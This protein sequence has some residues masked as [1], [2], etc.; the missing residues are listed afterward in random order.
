[1]PLSSP[2]LLQAHDMVY[3]PDYTTMGVD[4]QQQ[5]YQYQ[6]VYDYG[7][8]PHGPEELEQHASG[9]F[10]EFNT[11]ESATS[12]N[13][14]CTTIDGY[15]IS[16]HYDSSSP[17]TP[18]SATQAM[19]VMYSSPMTELDL[20]SPCFSPVPAAHYA[21]YEEE[22]HASHA[23]PTLSRSQSTPQLH[24]TVPFPAETTGL[25][26]PGNQPAG[27]CM[28]LPGTAAAEHASQPDAQHQTTPP[29]QPQAQA[30]SVP[31][32]APAHSPAPHH[33]CQC[34]CSSS[35][36]P[37]SHAYGP[38]PPGHFY[39][40]VYHP[41]W[42]PGQPWMHGQHQ[43]GHHA[44]PYHAPAPY[45]A[46]QQPTVYYP[47]GYPQHA[48][49]ARQPA[50]AVPSRPKFN[51]TRTISLPVNHATLPPY[52]GPVDW[53]KRP[54]APMAGVGSVDP[55][56]PATAAAIEA[57]TATAVAPAPPTPRPS[58]D[59]AYSEYGTASSFSTVQTVRMD[60]VCHPAQ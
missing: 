54:L 7:A 44:Y 56:A 27:L 59:R 20:N 32:P 31:A 30:Q 1:M 26:G 38:P 51:H 4:G 43:Q 8:T 16:S 33:S 15:A 11:C 49:P 5:P 3:S 47:Y 40:Q 6:L 36:H 42:Q 35:A 9:Y 23:M 60:Q 50:A 2:S 52:S 18:S 48:A 29:P 58:P 37:P 19:D 12:I 46:H 21:T 41:H 57:M 55:A 17:P 28:F 34:Q 45:A 24:Q 22:Q 39:P 25:A 53:S 10:T 13:T 14:L